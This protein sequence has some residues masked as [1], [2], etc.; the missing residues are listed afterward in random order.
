[1]SITSDNSSQN[2]GAQNFAFNVGQPIIPT[3]MRIGQSS[4]IKTKA[5]QNGGMKIVYRNR[6]FNNIVAEIIGLSP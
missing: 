3:L 2:Q 5:V 4:V 6:V 1:M